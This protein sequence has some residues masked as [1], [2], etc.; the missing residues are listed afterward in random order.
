ML[1]GLGEV[2]KAGALTAVAGS[3]SAAGS[4]EWTR[5]VVLSRKA[6]SVG[7]RDRGN[8]FAFGR[9]AFGATTDDF[10]SDPEAGDRFA[11]DAEAGM[12]GKEGWVR[13]GAL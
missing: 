5:G 11:P 13:T 2:A 8:D 7:W 1:I 10:A 3:S 4:V 12:V 9:A 6:R